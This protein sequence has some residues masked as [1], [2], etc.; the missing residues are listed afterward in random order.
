MTGKKE[1]LY[2]FFKKET[3][4]TSKTITHSPPIGS[5]IF[6]RIIYD[7]MLIFLKK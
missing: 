3:N 7:N 2:Q 1:T 4:K 5:E 6:E